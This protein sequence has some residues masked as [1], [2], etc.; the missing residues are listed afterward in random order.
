MAARGGVTAAIRE[1]YQGEREGCEERDPRR[2]RG[3]DPRAPEA[4]DPSAVR[5]REATA[6]REA[7]TPNSWRSRARARVPSGRTKAGSLTL[8]SVE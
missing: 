7:A 3:G 2:V 4:G 1:R 6:G 8:I 5:R